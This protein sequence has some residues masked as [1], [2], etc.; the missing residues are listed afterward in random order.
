MWKLLEQITENKNVKVIG[1]CDPVQ[2]GYYY[3]DE[4]GNKINYDLT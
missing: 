1:A 3:L 4:G 2:A